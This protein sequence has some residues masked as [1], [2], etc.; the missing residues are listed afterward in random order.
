MMQCNKSRDNNE[1]GE[2]SVLNAAQCTS[3]DP[4]INVVIG[5]IR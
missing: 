3:C 2:D 5:G 1:N 4:P